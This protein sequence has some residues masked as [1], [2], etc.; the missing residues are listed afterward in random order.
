MWIKVSNIEQ[1]QSLELGR[2]L[3]KYP[4]TGEPVDNLDVSDRE[5]I[6]VRIVTRN[7]PNLE[8]IDI[9]FIPSQIDHHIIAGLDN[10]ILG[11]MHKDYRDIVEENKYWLLTE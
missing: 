7:E 2:T 1:L 9:S 4:I 10:I 8:S 5:N 3:L 11:P 6:S